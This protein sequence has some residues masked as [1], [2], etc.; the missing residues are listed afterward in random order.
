MVGIEVDEDF[1]VI[2]A[3]NSEVGDFLSK[4]ML[5]RNEFNL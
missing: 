4:N 5:K 2:G 3:I 1:D